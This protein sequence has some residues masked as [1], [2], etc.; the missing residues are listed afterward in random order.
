MVYDIFGFDSGRTRL[1]CDQVAAAGYTVA[2]PD[3]FRGE[4]ASLGPQGIVWPGGS[5]N[6][7][8]GKYPPATTVLPDI[9]DKVI[10]FLKGK[11]GATKVGLLGFCY[12]AF[13]C[14]AASANSGISCCATAHPSLG[15]VGSVALMCLRLSLGLT[16]KRPLPQ[17]E[18]YGGSVTELVSS[19]K[20]PQLV[21]PASNDADI[22]K[23]RL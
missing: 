17:A 2:L 6:A 3:L 18:L 9:F 21:L 19:V 14:F 23:V 13:V 11:H 1:I 5:M 8:L 16:P 12:G 10:P 4:K 15:L 20:C 22:V 7:W